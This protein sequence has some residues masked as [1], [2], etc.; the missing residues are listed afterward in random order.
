M[1]KSINTLFLL[2]VLVTDTVISRSHIESI[3]S[4]SIP[5]GTIDLSQPPDQRWQKFWNGL[6]KNKQQAACVALESITELTRNLNF[7]ANSKNLLSSLIGDE[8]IS[9]G[10]GLFEVLNRDCEFEFKEWDLH[11][12]NLFYE[13]SDYF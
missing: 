4:T 12:T 11:V 7:P 10:R 8:Y 3:P 2:I 6:H 13:Y 9:E 1:L 5:T